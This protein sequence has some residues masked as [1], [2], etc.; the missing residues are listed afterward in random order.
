ML[1]SQAGFSVTNSTTFGTVISFQSWPVSVPCKIGHFEN[2]RQKMHFEIEDFFRGSERERN[3][4]W[5]AGH[6][7]LATLSN[8][9]HA[10][11]CVVCNRLCADQAGKSCS[12]KWF[13]NLFTRIPRRRYLERILFQRQVLILKL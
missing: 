2:T 13:A 10:S 9:R 12:S 11:I 3:A 4:V 1:L 7:S 6:Q 8:L 5:S